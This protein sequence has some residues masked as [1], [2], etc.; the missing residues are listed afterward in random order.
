MPGKAAKLD[1]RSASQDDKRTSNKTAVWHLSH[2][3]SPVC[4]RGASRKS[5]DY[6][7]DIENLHSGKAENLHRHRWGSGA[8]RNDRTRKNLIRRSFSGGNARESHW[9]YLSLVISR[10]M[11]Y[12]VGCS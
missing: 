7:S 10:S 2:D 9:R 3:Y 6:L 11:T 1:T 5:S 12:V 8:R 4:Y